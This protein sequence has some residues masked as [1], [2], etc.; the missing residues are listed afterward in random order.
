MKERSAALPIKKILFTVIVATIVLLVLSVF[1]RTV[2]AQTSGYYQYTV[3]DG[4]ATITGYTG[5]GGAVA[6]PA[7]LDSY[8]VSAIGDHAFNGCQSITGITIPES[9]IGIGNFSFYSCNSL[10]SV[11]L[12][13]GLTSIGDSAFYNCN[14]LIG[15]TVPSSVSSIGQNAFDECTALSSINVV[16][17]NTHFSSQDGVLFNQAKTQLL[18]YPVGKTGANYSIPGSVIEI[19]DYAFV[20]CYKYPSGVVIPSSVK[21][22]GAHAFD[23]TVL[24]S[25]AIP[26]SVSNIG[27]SA[28]GG[29]LKLTAINV[30]SA[31]ANY[32]SQ[33]GV[34]FNKAKT[35]LVQYPAGKTGSG[36]AIPNGITDISDCAFIGCSQYLKN[37][38]IPSGVTRI[39]DS[40]FEQCESLSS[41]T[42]PGSVNSIGKSAFSFC[43]SLNGINIPD[44]I[45]SIEDQ[46]FTACTSLSSIRIPSSVTSIESNAFSYCDGLSSVMI[47]DSVANI[48]DYAF[49]GCTSLSQAYFYGDAPDMG[50]L[51]FSQCGTGFTIYYPNDKTGY[52]NPWHDYRTEGCDLSTMPPMP[53][54]GQAGTSGDYT[55]WIAD[56]KA[57]ITGYT[58]PGGAVSIPSTLGGYP[59]T[60]IGA[61]VFLQDNHITKITIPGSVANIGTQ[62]FANCTTLTSVTL[63]SGVSH[64]GKQAFSGDYSITSVALPS[65]LSVIGES[66]FYACTNIKSITIPSS[67]TSME[68]YAFSYC[69]TLDKAY[70]T[71]NAP[72]MGL[73]IFTKCK[74]G[75]TIY[76]VSGKTG[77]TN[78]WCGY[79]TMI[80]NPSVKCTVSFNLNGYIG[81]MPP[82]PQTV[83]YGVKAGKAPPIDRPG[84]IF[85]GWYK[86]AACKNA[87]NFDKD[88]VLKNTVLYAKW[89]RDTNMVS[90]SISSYSAGYTSIK[91]SWSTFPGVSGYQVYRALSSNGTYSLI[92]T[93]SSTNFTNTGLK[94][95]T[96]YYYKVRAY[97]YSGSTKIYGKYSAVTSA[98]PVP[99]VV[100]GIKAA[101]YNPVNVKISWK[102]VSGRTG[103][104]IW[105][106]TSSSSGYKLIKTTT[107][108]SYKNTGLTTNTNYYSMVRAYR[109]VSGRKIYGKYS[110]VAAATPTLGTVVGAKA[111]MYSSSSNKLTWKAVSGRTGYEI[112]RATSPGGKYTLRGSTTKTLY[113]DK[114]LIPNTRYYYK[115][116]AYRTVNNIRRYGSFS[117][118]VNATPVLKTVSSLKAAAYSKTGTKLTWGSVSGRSG[119]EIWCSL[120]PN[121][122]F[123][124]IKS[125]TGTYYYHTGLVAGKTYYYKVRAY[126]V[127]GGA[128][129]YSGYSAMAYAIPHN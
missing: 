103:Y 74:A 84:Y 17:T 121:S 12:G 26:G 18:R 62:A 67:V 90:T 127:S 105:R 32:T 2:Y 82:D 89:T 116:R 81:T 37:V 51:A 117:G 71:G 4:K 79:T 16:T 59:V 99:A 8:P 77:Y 107:N 73:G 15:I 65:S 50:Q 30:D 66:A 34:L 96:M 43:I 110:G 64:I 106:S 1:E 52:T 125:L 85:G 100:T 101:K 27:P 9:V 40:A 55:Y 88:V 21:N 98:K 94:T 25:I 109:T 35:Q 39:G 45:T 7:A 111:S 72:T 56:G 3:S 102:A 78:P 38:T 87:W 112:W 5:P 46:T 44:G 95:G 75:F 49:A 113:Y 13:S 83:Y 118:I 53:G 126:C 11:T 120:S 14:N 47:P 29:C 6:I 24:T 92:K 60:A 63:Q 119:Y 57:V 123:V 68:N 124:L 20:G 129:K 108:T 23:H 93:T 22:I 86:E 61:S 54:M 91:V 104:E 115:I 33:N 114:N 41:L 128:K 10:K 70:F 42:L 122:G 31:N 48:A 97:R 76:T 69:V 36:Y 28:F 19:G 80:Y 58:G